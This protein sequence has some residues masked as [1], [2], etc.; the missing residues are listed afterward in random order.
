MHHGAGLLSPS[1][2][3]FGDDVFQEPDE[4]PAWQSG[5]VE[6]LDSS[7]DG[8]TDVP[9]DHSLETSLHESDEDRRSPATAEMRRGRLGGLTHGPI[10]RSPASAGSA[11]APGAPQG[12]AAWRSLGCDRLPGLGSL[13]AAGPAGAQPPHDQE[14]PWAAH[15]RLPPGLTPQGGGGGGGGSQPPGS[16]WGPSQGLP[17]GPAATATAR[18]STPSLLAMVKDGDESGSD[19]EDDEDGD[20]SHGGD[21]AKGAC[22]EQP[23]PGCFQAASA[24][25]GFGLPG[26]SVLMPA[27]G[28]EE[29][30]AWFSKLPSIGS[31]N[32]F[33]GTCDR[34]CFHPKG[35]CLNGWN[36]QH[37]HF[38][39][40]K[41]KR[42]NKKKGK[43][44]LGLD[45]SAETLSASA[46]GSLP[47]TPSDA[48]RNA[49]GAS[50]L[51][52]ASGDFAPQLQQQQ[53]QS[54]CAAPQ[55][56]P[57][58]AFPAPPAYFASDGGG[59]WFGQ[60][61][62]LAARPVLSATSALLG[63]VPSAVG[64]A[65]GYGDFVGHA[66]ALPD[67][68]GFSTRMEP[69][70]AEDRDR[71]DEYI[72]QLEMENRYL[73]AYV[74]QLVGSSPGAVL[75]PGDHPAAA[76][77][78]QQALPSPTPPPPE[79]SAQPLPPSTSSAGAAPASQSLSP[80]AAPFWPAGQMSVMSA[81]APAEDAPEQ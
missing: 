11:G 42:K 38:D 51:G 15:R 3:L 54:A 12:A 50:P 66:G 61:D 28:N 9:P 60:A 16:A 32:H 52:L 30:G 55:A 39:H 81:A 46:D 77:E 75:P 78:H 58:G 73:R 43:G 6:L 59:A 1:T 64:P 47:V 36:C 26:T 72:R 70:F 33:D 2:L 18:A 31:A 37:C 34:C 29:L 63:T 68:V 44:R 74:A 14:G 76:P 24:M 79:S 27:A 10:A 53:Q 7:D 17:G 57:F 65:A 20:R 40:E 19:G 45:D 13:L 48:A 35:R 23:Q 22:G 4:K 41:R 69:T 8:Q 71:K 21:H 67:G 5:L 80:A 56:D 62:P 25:A 49:F